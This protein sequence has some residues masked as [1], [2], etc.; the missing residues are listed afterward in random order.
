[1]KEAGRLRV[2]EEWVLRRIF[3]P[4]MQRSRENYKTRTLKICTP[5]QIVFDCSNQEE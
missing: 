5:Y 4:K 3:G 2:F 1:L